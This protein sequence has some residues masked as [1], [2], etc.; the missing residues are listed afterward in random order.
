MPERWARRCSTVTSSS[1]SGRSS[2]STRTSRRGR[3]RAGPPRSGSS[4]V[5]AVSA[6]VPLAM[7]NRVSTA[8]GMP[9]PRCARPYAL[10]SSTRPPRST[11]TT[12]ENPVA[13]ATSVDRALEVI[14]PPTVAAD[15]CQLTA[16]TGS[17]S[18]CTATAE[19]RSRPTDRSATSAAQHP[20]R[21]ARARGR[22][23][24]DPQTGLRRDSEARP[25]RPRG[26]DPCDGHRHRA[27]VHLPAPHCPNAPARLQQPCPVCSQDHSGLASVTVE[28]TAYSMSARPRIATITRPGGG[29]GRLPMTPRAGQGLPISR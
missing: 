10:A 2:P 14:H 27:R 3:G 1:I 20:L 18:D 25:A 22:R 4:T 28:M 26:S 13:T 9:Q 21:P 5:R 11:R 16:S 17:R 15:R 6:F 19:P 7:P 8:L 29:A 24:R 23:R 12:P